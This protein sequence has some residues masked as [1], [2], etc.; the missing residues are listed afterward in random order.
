M[1]LLLFWPVLGTLAWICPTDPDLTP[2]W[3]KKGLALSPPTRPLFRPFWPIYGLQDGSKGRHQKGRIPRVA[4]SR[5]NDTPK[6]FV[7]GQNNKNTKSLKCSFLI[8]RH[9]VFLG[10]TP[11]SPQIGDLARP[12]PRFTSHMPSK[13]T[14]GSP[15]RDSTPA[16]GLKQPYMA[17]SRGRELGRQ[18]HLDMPSQTHKTQQAWK[19]VF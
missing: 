11:K 1:V 6:R 13:R 15:L 4:T 16:L 9:F 14:N 5:A 3:S 18:S 10:I 7:R 17:S 19:H 8:S 12:R 2:F